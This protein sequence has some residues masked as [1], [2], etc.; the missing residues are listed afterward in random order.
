MTTNFKKHKSFRRSYREDYLREFKSESAITLALN[1]FKI[2][3]KNWKLFLPLLLISVTLFTVLVGL[4]SESTYKNFQSALDSTSGAENLGGFARAGLILVSA[5]TTGGFSA[6]TEVSTV[7]LVLIFI[8]IWLTTIYFLRRLKKHEHPTL[9][10]GLY[11][12]LAPFVSTLIVL[13]AVIVDLIPVFALTIVYSTAL[14]TNFLSTPFYALI[15][16]IL[17]ALLIILSLYL[18]SRSLIALVAVSAPGLYPFV[19]ISTANK[20]MYSRRIHFLSRVFVLFLTI[21]LLFAVVLI[22]TIMLDTGLKAGSENLAGFPL[23]PIVMMLMT[24]FSFIY[25]ATFLYLYY[26]RLLNYDKKELKHGKS[27]S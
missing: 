19:A 22:P 16:L 6:F 27:R 24:V 23:V 3:F 13:C 9:R 18:L 1:S 2:L 8:F 21:A 25:S 5:V 14:K 10:E 20:L 26:R 12:S 7:F 15:F 11:N 17:A 4:M